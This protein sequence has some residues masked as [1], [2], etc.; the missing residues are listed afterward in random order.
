MIKKS[1]A[2]EFMLVAFG[3][4]IVIAAG[5]NNLIVGNPN[6][7][8]NTLGVLVG[9]T[10]QIIGVIKIDMNINWDDLRT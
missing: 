6:E 4:Q 5:M 1:L 10:M 9:G 3:I 8:L 7:F 2:F